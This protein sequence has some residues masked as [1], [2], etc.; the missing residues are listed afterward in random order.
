MSKLVFINSTVTHDLIMCYCWFSVEYCDMKNWTPQCLKLQ[1]KF[2]NANKELV[3]KYKKLQGLFKTSLWTLFWN[4]NLVNKYK[5]VELAIASI[6]LRRHWE[7]VILTKT[8]SVGNQILF[9][10][11]LATANIFMLSLFIL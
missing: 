9:K 8:T 2:K 1:V 11:V 10:R 6:N 5:Q 4:N 3:Y 7:G